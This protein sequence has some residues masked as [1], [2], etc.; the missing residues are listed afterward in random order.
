MKS[1]H[2][3]HEEHPNSED[4]CF[5]IITSVSPSAGYLVLLQGVLLLFNSAFMNV[6]NQIDV[7]VK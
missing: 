4:I 2:V 7:C 5:G 6:V 3:E 1:T